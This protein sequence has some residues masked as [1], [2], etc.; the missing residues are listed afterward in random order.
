VA[1][2]LDFAVVRHLGDPVVHGLAEAFLT[3]AMPEELAKLLV[4]LL[5]SA[6][7]RAFDE[8]MDGVVYGALAGLGFATLENLLY[9]F[10][11]GLGLAVLRAV[12]A[13][14][15]HACCGALVGHYVA[16]RRF[17]SHSGRFL[18]WQAWF[19][20][21]LIHGL[22]D[23]P[24]LTL[25]QLSN[26]APAGALVLVGMTIATLLVGWG[27]T[28]RLV[29]RLRRE[30]VAG[31]AAAA[32]A[33]GEPA[34]RDAAIRA[35]LAEDERPSTLAAVALLLGGG[36]LASLGGMFLLGVLLGL[37]AGVQPED[38]SALLIGGVVIGLLPLLAGFALFF[39]GLRRLVRARGSRS[40]P[41]PLLAA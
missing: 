35:A 3:A 11:G 37:L 30:Q 21:T 40:R 33:Q 1:L 14:P 29:R 12:T 15:M 19:W 17:S 38:L 16:Q 13:V 31:V 28:V 20:P 34:A 25:R 10:S 27:W 5:Y 9:V 32:V 7:H 2:P 22:Y 4:V 8:P 41:R 26:P 6:R 36:L 39:L 24:L 18:L 23:F